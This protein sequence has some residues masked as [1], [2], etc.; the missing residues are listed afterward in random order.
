MLIN[1]KKFQKKNYITFI[2]KL[3]DSKGYDLF[4]KSIIK[5]LDEFPKWKAFSLGDEERRK[6][7]LVIK[8]IMN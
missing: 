2:G 7:L 5:I 4:A 1:E 6:I 8:I 3:N